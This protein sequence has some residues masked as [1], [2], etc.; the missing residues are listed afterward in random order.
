VVAPERDAIDAK[1]V[2]DLG[3]IC[4]QERRHVVID[5]ASRPD[6]KY[7]PYEELIMDCLEEYGVDT[8]TAESVLQHGAVLRDAREACRTKL[9]RRASSRKAGVTKEAAAECRKQLLLQHA[10]AKRDGG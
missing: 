5:C 10:R 8:P 6:A 3:A 2:V 9:E 7:G 1:E 4:R